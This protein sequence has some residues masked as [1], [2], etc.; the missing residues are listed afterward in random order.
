MRNK[1]IFQRPPNPRP[2]RIEKYPYFR[3]RTI[4]ERACLQS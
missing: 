4:Y 1:N 3:I 2:A